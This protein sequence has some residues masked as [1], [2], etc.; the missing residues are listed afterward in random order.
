[1]K[2]EV[3][4]SKRSITQLVKDKWQWIMRLSHNAAILLTAVALLTVGVYSWFTAQDHT[5]AVHYAGLWVQFS[6]IL[7]GIQGAWLFV[8][9]LGK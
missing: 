4:E 9:Q 7:I 6:G 2:K 3:T 5:F 8:K 1:M